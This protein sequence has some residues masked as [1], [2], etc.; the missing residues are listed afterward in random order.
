M[1]GGVL[2]T[3]RYPL[4]IF[5]PS[6]FT[7]SFPMT[8][9]ADLLLA[10]VIAMHGSEHSVSLP[11]RARTAG[12]TVSAQAGFA[13][14]YVA[15]GLRDPSLLFLRVAP[16]AVVNVRTEASLRVEGGSR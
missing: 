12:G 11:V 5:R 16:I 14:P 1:H 2:E 13:I 7:G 8:G 10:G 4:A 15:W 3:E 9:A 6:R